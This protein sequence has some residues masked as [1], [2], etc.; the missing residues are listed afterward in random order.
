MSTWPAL[1][2]VSLC[3]WEELWGAKVL[4][5]RGLGDHAQMQLDRRP[6]EADQWEESIEDNA[7]P[8]VEL[9]EQ[10]HSAQGKLQG[11]PQGSTP[12][13]R[14]V[15]HRP[16]PGRA[17]GGPRAR[18]GARDGA[19]PPPV[20]YKQDCPRTN[21]TCFSRTVTVRTG[22]RP[23]TPALAPDQPQA[24]RNSNRAPPK[25]AARPN[26]GRPEGVARGGARGGA[27]SA[28][29]GVL[30]LD[31]VTQNALSD[32]PRKETALHRGAGDERKGAPESMPRGGHFLKL[33]PGP[34]VGGARGRGLVFQEGEET[35]SRSRRSWIWNQFF[36]IE[37]YSG[38]EPVLIGR[39]H[40][41][42]DRG[43]GRT[44]YVLRG[45]G[46]G[47]VFV[48][49]EK[50][51][52]IHVTKPLDREEKDEYRLIATATDR[53]TDR[54]LEPSSQFIIRVQDINDN[55]PLFQS[56]PYSATVPEMAN[57]GTSIIQV[58]ATDADDPT[59]GNSARLVYT[60]VQG[61]E[62]FSVD[63]QTGIVRTAVPDLDR[64]TQAEHLLVLQAKDMGG[65][66]G[67]LSG[68]TTVTIHLSDVND[69]PPRFRQTQASDLDAGVSSLHTEFGPQSRQSR[70]SC[71]SLCRSWQ[72]PGRRWGRLSATDADLDDNAK[73]EY[74]I[75]EG[76]GGDTFNITGLNQEAIITL[77]KM[78]LKQHSFKIVFTLLKVENCI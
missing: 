69:N 36:V 10:S 21:L 47:S 6:A 57:I 28:L 61:Q 48:I 17:A 12:K 55:P 35:R 2:L 24:R 62:Y 3:L 51:G 39:L 56:A 8:L 45:E 40:T 18:A 29:R 22:V 54:A 31:A 58:T 37:E 64:E 26:P 11:V 65:H 71:R 23:D 25:S 14:S 20:R 13:N 73:L 42:M 19:Q 4:R 78:L 16:G 15:Y 52:N 68:T 49:D 38:P 66:L 30:D 50:T 27:S 9:S 41:D 32:G 67:G 59:Y 77:N 43:D 72:Y 75:L 5:R 7:V 70:G 63:P 60:L 34:G 46:A 33:E 44:K 76:E 1:L 74:T 53:Q